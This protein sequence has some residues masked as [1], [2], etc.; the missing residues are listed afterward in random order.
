MRSKFSGI[1]LSSTSTADVNRCAQHSFS[2]LTG[3]FRGSSPS[4]ILPKKI[5]S[6]PDKTRE[7]YSRPSTWASSPTSYPIF[8]I[9]PQLPCEAGLLTVVA[10][11]NEKCPPQSGASE[12][13][14]PS[15]WRCLGRFSSDSFAGGSTSWRPVRRFCKLK[16]LSASIFSLCYTTTV[17]M[18]ALN[19]LLQPPF[20]LLTCLPVTT[21]SQ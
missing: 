20:C 3:P 5:I 4:P 15:W 13:L 8:P 1:Y 14:V 16:A 17:R 11:L 19:F 9:I 12:H 10:C 21:D 2:G 7:F 6:C 18:R